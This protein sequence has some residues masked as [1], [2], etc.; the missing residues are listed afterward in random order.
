VI[1]NTVLTT[2]GSHERNHQTDAR[3]NL[4]ALFR[5]QKKMVIEF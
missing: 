1:A 5:D 4:L 2:D 3:G